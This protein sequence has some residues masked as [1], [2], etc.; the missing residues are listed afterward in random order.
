[1]AISA[2]ELGRRL[3]SFDNR[4]Q[5]VK[6][7]RRALNKAAKTQVTPAIRAHAV[8]ILPKRGG[9]NEYV[10]S[11]SVAALISYA[12]R[13]AGIRLRGRKKT[14]AGRSDLKRIDAGTVRAPSWGH[15][16]AA[17]WHT[18]SVAPGWFTDAADSPAFRDTVDAEVDSAL[19]ELRRL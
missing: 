2:E 17:S 14:R 7:M 16:T 5:I 9:L 8:A 10:A 13:S 18:Q 15:R 12:S 6:A 19:G 11:A 3:R 1:M 4:R